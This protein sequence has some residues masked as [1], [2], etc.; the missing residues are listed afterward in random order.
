MYMYLLF[1]SS[2]LIFCLYFPLS[3][4][5]RYIYIYIYTYRYNLW[6][7]TPLSAI[8]QVYR[9]GQY[10]WWNE[11]GVPDLSQ[12]TDK[13][14]HIMCIEC[15]SSSTGFEL[16]TLVVIGTDCRG[17]CKYINLKVVF[18]GSYRTLTC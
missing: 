16:I 6:C 3:T 18:V 4:L 17:S 10:Y 2:S 14:F 13:L 9:G 15:T 7:L 12:V 8:F 1:S 11:P 5:S